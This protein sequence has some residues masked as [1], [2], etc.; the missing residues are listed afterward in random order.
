MAIPM[1]YPAWSA[2]RQPASPFNSISLSNSTLGIRLDLSVNSTHLKPGDGIAIT[3][4]EHNLH[5]SSNEVGAW[6]GWKDHGLR[7]APGPGCPTADLPIGFFVLNGYYTKDSIS[8]GHPLQLYMPG[9]AYWGSISCPEILS[10]RSYVFDPES[11][12]ATIMGTCNPCST[13]PIELQRQVAGLVDTTQSFHSPST[14]YPFSHG[15]YTLVGG[16]EWGDLLLLH[17]TVS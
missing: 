5:L 2:S 8:N 7:F 16:D 10:A 4:S 15:V 12:L 11:S 9:S 3:L 1:A 6:W 17:F 13:V 14:F